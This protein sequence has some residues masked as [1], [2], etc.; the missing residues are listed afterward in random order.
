M[1]IYQGRFFM[2][3]FLAI[4]WMVATIS[5]WQTENWWGAGLFLFLACYSAAVAIRAATRL[6]KRSIRK[7]QN[8]PDEHK[9]INHHQH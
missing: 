3:S 7:K 6:Q 4:L 1:S 9:P 5:Y 2:A 8:Q